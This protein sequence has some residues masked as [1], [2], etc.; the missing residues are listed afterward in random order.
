MED[1]GI[2]I[3]DTCQMLCFLQHTETHAPT[4]MLK[5]SSGETALILNINYQSHA[6]MSHI[7][8]DTHLCPCVRRR[9]YVVGEPAMGAVLDQ[10]NTPDCFRKTSSGEAVTCQECTFLRYAF[11][12]FKCLKAADISI[13]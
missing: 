13:E 2:L 12:A 9:T 3:P 4:N 6:E 1:A 11:K 10:L 5:T 8:L 7:N